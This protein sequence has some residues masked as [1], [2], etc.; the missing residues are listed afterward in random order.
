VISDKEQE[1]LRQQF[2]AKADSL[3]EAAL[4]Q[5]FKEQF[6]LS[7]IEEVVGQLKFGLTSLLVES[8]IEV[9]AKQM[10]GPGP[11]CSRC[12]REMR[13]K[14]EKPRQLVTSQGEIEFKR[15]YYYCEHCR[16]GVFPP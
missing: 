3:F 6:T 13:D 14:G 1:Q 2:R 15:R 9:Q 5:G 10:R 11:K 8:L 16:Q 4:E 12:G 7:Q